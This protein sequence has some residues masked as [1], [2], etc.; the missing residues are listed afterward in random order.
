M[1]VFLWCVVDL[2]LGQR[3]TRYW[4]CLRTGDLLGSV[5][6]LSVVI[7][8]AGLLGSPVQLLVYTS[9][10]SESSVSDVAPWLLLMVAYLAVDS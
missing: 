3:G 4:R 2:W 8:G 1:V 9:V 10:I 7:G 6:P 5:A